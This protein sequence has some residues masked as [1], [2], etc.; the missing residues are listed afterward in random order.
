MIK[1]KIEKIAKNKIEKKIENPDK[2]TERLEA[3]VSQ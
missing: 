1:K 2:D 3:T